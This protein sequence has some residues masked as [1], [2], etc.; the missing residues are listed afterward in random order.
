MTSQCSVLL[1]RPFAQIVL[2]WLNSCGTQVFIPVSIK[3]PGPYLRFN[4]FI[5]NISTTFLH[6]SAQKCHL[7]SDIQG[8]SFRHIF[9]SQ[10]F[11]ACLVLSLTIKFAGYVII[12]G[13]SSLK[14]WFVILY[15]CCWAPVCVFFSRLLSY[16]SPISTHKQS[17]T[18]TIR[19]LVVWEIYFRNQTEQPEIV[20]G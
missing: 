9:C 16:P 5:P 17:T 8:Y 4:E 14:F 1:E 15:V 19:D 13:C 6:I 11:Y 20:L 7:G 2:S 10:H 18:A 3:Y 12:F